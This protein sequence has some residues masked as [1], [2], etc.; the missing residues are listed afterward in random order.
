MSWISWFCDGGYFNFTINFCIILTQGTY[1]AGVKIDNWPL[2][3]T[4]ICI[5]LVYGVAV[6]LYAKSLL[7]DLL[8][9]AVINFYYTVSKQFKVL[10]RE[11]S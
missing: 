7:I 11:P 3:H 4:I 1:T 5:L 2:S 9:S 8:T 10:S 6:Y